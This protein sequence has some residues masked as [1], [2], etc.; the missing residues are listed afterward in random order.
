MGEKRDGETKGLNVGR[1]LRRRATRTNLPLFRSVE[2]RHFWGFTARDCGYVVAEMARRLRVSDRLLQ[3][4]FQR[5]AACAPKKWVTA[6]RMLAASRL[7][8]KCE[9]I[10]EVA[11][12]LHY[13]QVSHFCR[14]FKVFYQQTPIEYLSAVRDSSVVFPLPVSALDNQCR[15]SAIDE[16]CSAPAFEG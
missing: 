6:E 4:H 15:V 13:R 9:S 8:V 7:L 1:A 10:K 12:D 14:D 5:H 11:F 3:R 16:D 2:D